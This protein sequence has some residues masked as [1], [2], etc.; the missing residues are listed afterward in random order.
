MLKVTQKPGYIISWRFFT[1]YEEFE[2]WQIKDKPDLIELVPHSNYKRANDLEI[3]QTGI[4]AFFYKPTEDYSDY[5]VQ[6]C[7]SCQLTF[8]IDAVIS[9]EDC[10]LCHKCYYEIHED[11]TG[12]KCRDKNNLHYVYLSLAE[13]LGVRNFCQEAKCKITTPPAKCFY[14]RHIDGLVRCQLCS[15]ASEIPVAGTV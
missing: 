3:S 7:E 9:G 4:V 8:D 11:E 5:D 12:E 1:N 6:T 13:T 15:S 10:Y 14:V 2:Q